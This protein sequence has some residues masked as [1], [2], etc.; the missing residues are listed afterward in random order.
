MTSLYPEPGPRPDR[1]VAETGLA[2]DTL[3][4]RYDELQM[5]NPV[6][7]HSARISFDLVERAMAQCE[8]VLEIGSGTGRE[9]LRLASMGKTVVALDP[10]QRS[11]QI[12]R[13][14]AERLGLSNHV[15][16]KVAP[17]SHAADV[18]DGFERHSF[19]GAFSSFAL[20]YEP[21]LAS[22][23]SQVWEF[24]KPGAPFLC[25]IFNRFCLTEIVLQAPFLVPRRGLHRLEGL[26]RMPVDK[27]HVAV[28]SYTAAGVKSLFSPYF[29]L[30]ALQAILA[31]VPP[32]Y[33]HSL[34]RRLGAF[35]Q[36]WEEFDVR[37]STRWPFKFLG[38][39]TAYLFRARTRP[40]FRADEGR[41]H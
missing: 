24:L 17:A 25:S 8:I 31:V 14:K 15:V 2:Y 26:M 21:D 4:E 34:M 37:V 3:S 9:T 18:L 41:N 36:I 19:D 16:T 22:V 12:L 29:D 7:A 32:N 11:L 39:H 5:R 35:R 20:S 30:E 38:S 6:L 40:T 1:T 27:F 23:P 10:S 28:R 33:L 13:G